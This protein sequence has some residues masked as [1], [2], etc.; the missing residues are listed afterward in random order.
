VVILTAQTPN[1]D[2]MMFTPDVRLTAGAA[3][4]F[5]RRMFKPHRSALAERLFALD[6]VEA[7]YVAPAFVT[8]TRS[9]TGRTWPALRLEAIAAIA[10]HLASGAAALAAESMGESAPAS[11]RPGAD[12]D[13]EAE[14]RTVLHLWVR[15]G[16]ARDGGDIR[17]ERFDATTSVL[18]ISMHGACGG[19][20]ASRLTLK[21]GVER[22]VRRYVPE[23][24]SVEAAVDDAPPRPSRLK[25]WLA[26]LPLRAG[27]SKRPVF[28]HQGR[29]ISRGARAARAAPLP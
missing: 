28:T 22:I 21:A 9:P 6:D 3:A 7:V 18:W 17:L 19:C 14:I 2:A 27:E 24:M 4:A 10:E 26:S 20:P 8:V 25:G 13:L 23:V 11:A 16:V 29:E 1:P 15:P 5:T 12:A